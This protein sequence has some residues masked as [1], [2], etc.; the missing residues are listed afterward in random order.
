MVAGRQPPF[1]IF[2]SPPP[3]ERRFKAQFC[4]HATSQLKSLALENTSHNSFAMSQ[5]LTRNFSVLMDK[6]GWCREKG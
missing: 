3:Q 1:P 2:P 6:V 5:E 4:V